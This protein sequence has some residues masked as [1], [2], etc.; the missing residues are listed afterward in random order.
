MYKHQVHHPKRYHNKKLEF[1]TINGPFRGLII[2]TSKQNDLEPLKTIINQLTFDHPNYLFSNNDKNKCII[3]YRNPYDV[4]AILDKYTTNDNYTIALYRDEISRSLHPRVLYITPTK[5]AGIT[6]LIQEL[7]GNIVSQNKFSIQAQFAT[8][9]QTTIAHEEL[10][11]ECPCKFAYRSEVPQEEEQEK[12]SEA[13]GITDLRQ[14][15]EQ[16]NGPKSKNE[17]SRKSHFSPHLIKEIKGVVAQIHSHE[18]NMKKIKNA[19]KNVDLANVSWK[20]G[21]PE[22][23]ETDEESEGWDTMSHSGEALVELAR[24]YKELSSVTNV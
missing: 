5:N 19:S 12:Q 9:L 23:M 13:A 21:T 8:F 18:E 6:Q 24:I 10:R 15:L 11:K 3:Y 22:T 20:K 4:A 1:P 2:T 7:G 16:K 17:G 14:I